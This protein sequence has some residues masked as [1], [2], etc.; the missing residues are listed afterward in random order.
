MQYSGPVPIFGWTLFH[1]LSSN[2]FPGSWLPIRQQ[3]HFEI[4]LAVDRVANVLR[5]PFTSRISLK[6]GEDFS[7]GPRTVCPRIQFDEAIRDKLLYYRTTIVTDRVTRSDTGANMSSALCRVALAGTRRFQ[8]PR[9][10]KNLG[11]TGG[12]GMAFK[13]NPYVEVRLS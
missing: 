7:E 9:M 6:W 3:E 10:V 13:T 11:V 2:D 1:F 8:P 5:R 4:S 12:R